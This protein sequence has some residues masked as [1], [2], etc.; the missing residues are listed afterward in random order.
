MLSGIAASN[1]SFLADLNNTEQR[2]SRDSQQLSSTIRVN[3]A[4]DD[5]GAVT[6]LLDYQNQIAQIAQIVSNLNQQQAVVSTADGVLQTAS[7]L[8]NQLI[9]LGTQGATG[10]A[11]AESRT[12]LGEQ[13]QQIAQQL[14]SIANTNVQGQYIFGGDAPGTQPYTYDWSSPEGVVSSGSPTNTLAIH[15]LDGTSIVPGL[16]AGQIFDAQLSGGG[17][18]DPGNVFQAVYQL[19][20]ALL[21]NDQTGIQNALASIQTAAAHL[22]HSS[23]VYGEIENW[24]QQAVTTANARSTNL[25]AAVSSLRDTDVAAAATDLSQGQVALNAALAAQASLP[26]KSLF[27]YLA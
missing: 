10:T 20:T 11:T 18:P 25:T 7:G 5:P 26:T 6:P 9:S 27:S 19:G 17:G 14:V 1:A 15:G 21:N 16:T 24:M 23:T 12:N 2:I 8:M 13:V 4:S 22:S 3:V